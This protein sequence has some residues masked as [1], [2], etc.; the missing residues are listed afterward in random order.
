MLLQLLANGIVAGC[1][2]ALVAMGFGLI[3]NTTK[4]FHMAHGVVY[5]T[6]AYIFYTFARGIGLSL[7]PSF[8]IALSFA[9]LLGVGIEAF[10]YWPLFKKKAPLGVVLISSLGI[11]IF[12]VNLIAMIYG[13]ETKILSPGV[14]RTFHLGSVILTRTQVLEML[15]FVLLFPLFLLMLKKTKLGRII[16]ALADNPALITVLGVDVRRVRIYIFALGSLLAGVASSLV[17]L[18]VGMDPHV[19]IG[20]FLVAAVAM[21]IGGVGVFE[22]AVVGAFLLGILQNLVIWKTSARWTEALTFLVLI[23]FLLTRP[24]GI[25]GRKRRLEEL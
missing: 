13:N 16:R 14:E 4:I 1:V 6:S 7:I 19:G 9:V 10:I 5:T 11:Y 15:A 8:L 12:L 3:Y 24:Q 25:L 22:G 17:A 2:Y 18:D 21:I 20:A 23:L